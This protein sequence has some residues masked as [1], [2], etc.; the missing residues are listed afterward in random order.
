MAINVDRAFRKLFKH[1]IYCDNSE[2]LRV[3]HHLY[4][5]MDQIHQLAAT[6]EDIPVLDI[7]H[8]VVVC[9][10]GMNTHISPIKSIE[11]VLCMGWLNDG[12]DYNSDSYKVKAGNK[13]GRF[14]NMCDQQKYLSPAIMNENLAEHLKTLKH[15]KNV[16]VDANGGVTLRERGYLWIY[17]IRLGFFSKAENDGGVSYLV[18][19]GKNHWHPIQPNQ[20]AARLDKL[21]KY[22]GG[23]MI[24]LIRCL[25]YWCREQLL[26][27]IPSSL[28][29][30][31]VFNYCKS[32]FSPLSEFSDLDISGALQAI[33]ENV[34]IECIDPIGFRGDLNSLSK[35]DRDTI[36]KQAFSDYLKAKSARNFEKTNKVD[37]SIDKWS[38]LFGPEFKKYAKQ[39]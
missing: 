24:D 33:H 20:I 22:H 14:V 7:D 34:L 1:E 39:P 18:P 17:N 9:D 26:P 29:E 2:L 12:L 37:R 28:L 27:K 6:A 3:H 5:T 31:M 35:E 13:S 8:W 38:E 19:N 23:F 21:N 10:Y 36:S 30:A 32:K 15:A 11:V 16:T 4:Q 25:K